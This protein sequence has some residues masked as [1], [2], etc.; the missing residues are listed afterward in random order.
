MKE[1]PDF[2]FLLPPSSFLL[3][4]SYFAATRFASRLLCR[5][6]VLGWMI[7]LRLARSSCFS[8]S[9]NAGFASLVPIRPRSFLRAV[10]RVLRWLRL[11]AVRPVAWRIC[12]LADLV[13]GTA[14]LS[15]MVSVGSA[16]LSIA[17]AI[18]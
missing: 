8:A 11:R 10:R 16:G 18:S 9:R 15:L 4:P 6:A 14:A 3:P 5:A 1:E 12:F 17:T 13:L 2:F 7:P